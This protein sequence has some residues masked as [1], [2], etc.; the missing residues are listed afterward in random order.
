MGRNQQIQVRKDTAIN[1]KNVNPELVPGEI[2]LETDTG[3]TKIGVPGSGPNN[4]SL[5]NSLP[6][7]TYPA[8]YTSGIGTLLTPLSEST[9]QPAFPKSTI[10]LK[11]GM[12]DFRLQLR[13]GRN[14]GSGS[15]A[16]CFKLDGAAS[17]TT[18]QGTGNSGFVSSP[19]ITSYN[20]TSSV[21]A[22]SGTEIV[23]A[24]SIIT[25]TKTI[26][27]G[28]FWSI[29]QGILIVPSGGS[30]FTIKH[31]YNA[32]LTSGSTAHTLY[33]SNYCLIRY[34]GQ[35]NSTSNNNV[36]IGPWS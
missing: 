28:A 23:D 14:N 11:Q 33:P 15:A 6:A 5:W 26:T 27:S 32:N 18:F 13:E 20:D 8:Y 19:P 30:T 16:L 21:W 34:I 9:A 12:Y 1:W 29:F 10:T 2:G 24:S 22:G 35:D 17:G 25:L 4:G 7:T 36:S 3:I 31:S